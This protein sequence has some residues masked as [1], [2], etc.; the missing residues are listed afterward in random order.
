LVAFSP[1]LGTIGSFMTQATSEDHL[2]L[3]GLYC[4]STDSY[5]GPLPHD[6]EAG[7]I[8]DDELHACMDVVRALVYRKG[9]SRLLMPLTHQTQC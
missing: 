3:P 9:V 1:N 2:F 7:R 6:R 5:N 4:E 8:T